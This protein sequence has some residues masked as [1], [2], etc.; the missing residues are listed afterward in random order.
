MTSLA[1]KHA[2]CEFFLALAIAAFAMP[3]TTFADARKAAAPVA[4]E[5]TAV[6]KVTGSEGKTMTFDAAALAKLPQQT[7]H[8][9]A[10]GKSFDCTGP[11][12]IDL[13]TTVGAASGEALRGKNLAIYV[14]AS[15]AD[16][17]QAVFS[18]AELDPGMS[19]EYA[20]IVT[21]SCEGHALDAKEGPFRIIAPRDKRPARW[22]REL[23]ALDVLRAT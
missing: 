5:A 12:L 7:I 17:Y 20:P 13:L 4:A 21:T 6:L 1:T 2:G 11:R 18:L 3:S 10:H 9:E 8:A 14:R 16:G 23:T 19:G 22:V 15:A